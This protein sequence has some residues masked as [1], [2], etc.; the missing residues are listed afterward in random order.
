MQAA[1][2]RYPTAFARWLSAADFAL[3]PVAEV[4]LLGDPQAAEMQALRQGLWSVYRPN[5]IAAEASYPPPAGSPEL[6]FDR[7]LLD[8]KP[9]AYVC[10]G[11]VCRQPVGDAVAL[12]QV[13]STL[14]EV[15]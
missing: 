9:A 12:Q 3:G 11:F 5:L 2:G 13:L 7:P 15:I 8:G 4:A 10:L 1:A 6:L 14:L